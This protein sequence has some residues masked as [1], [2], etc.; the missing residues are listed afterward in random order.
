M[1]R[2]S[3]FISVSVVGIILNS[4]QFSPSESFKT[5]ILFILS[6]F[7]TWCVLNFWITVKKKLLKASETFP[8][9]WTYQ[10]FLINIFFM[11]YF[12]LCSILFLFYYF[13]NVLQCCFLAF[14]IILS[15]ILKYLLGN[16]FV[17]EPSDF[18]L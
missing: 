8:R 9:F 5:V 15:R 12:L 14:L 4:G 13:V 16:A 10:L 11:L 1:N 2:H 3:K 18:L 7:S 6:S 17:S